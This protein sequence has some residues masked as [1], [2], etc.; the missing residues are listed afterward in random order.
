MSII[1]SSL[2]RW[3]DII[4]THLCVLDFICNED[5]T[6]LVFTRSE[7]QGRQ[8]E[9]LNFKHSVFSFRMTN[10]ELMDPDIVQLISKITGGSLR[11][12]FLMDNS[13]HIKHLAEISEGML[14]AEKSK[15][16]IIV[17]ENMFYEIIALAEPEIS[18]LEAN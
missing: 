3:Q 5:A 11:G 1:K 17:D 6:Y 4:C 8:R 10:H 16:F 13:E 15:H 9:I 18:L 2:T 12:I 14:D 7:K